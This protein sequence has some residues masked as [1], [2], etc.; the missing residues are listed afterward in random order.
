MRVAGVIG[1]CG[2]LL[3]MVE[4]AFSQSVPAAAAHAEQSGCVSAN[5]SY[6]ELVH[7]FDYNTHEPLHMQE[8]GVTQQQGASIHDIT[9]VSQGQTVS[10]YL[11]T[12]A[13]QGPFAAILFMHWLD[14]SPTANRTEF[15]QEAVTLAQKGVVSLL[16]QGLYPWIESPQSIQHDCAATIRQTIVLRR[17]LDLL[18]ANK[19][20]DHTRVAFV[21]HDYGAMYGAILSG[22]EK[23]FKAFDLIAPTARFSNWNV[24]FFL[25]TL[26]PKQRLDYTVATASVDPMNYVG[27][28]DQR[29]I[30]FQFARQD[31]FVSL[32]DV[33]NLLEVA[34]DTATFTLYQADHSL[35]DGLSQQDRITWLSGQL[36]LQ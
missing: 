10:A 9:Y 17:G 12:P 26:T 32:A 6:N 36:G 13:G 24:P 7:Q 23:R 21:G 1:A 31:V 28:A 35:T 8:V 34:S 22:V 29:P 5:A 19:T 15:L 16:P 11:V 20:V 3:L 18:L 2:V 25:D 14:S 4:F 33:N 27:H 30:F